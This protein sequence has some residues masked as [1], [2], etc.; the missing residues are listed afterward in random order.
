MTLGVKHTKNWYVFSEEGVDPS[1]SLGEF[2]WCE[3][4]FE[5]IFFLKVV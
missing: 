1:Y 4:Y 2:I 5:V 3:F